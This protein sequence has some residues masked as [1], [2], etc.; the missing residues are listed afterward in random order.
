MYLVYIIQNQTLP[1]MKETSHTTT[2]NLFTQVNMLANDRLG[3]YLFIPSSKEII[4]ADLS[5]QI[6]FHRLSL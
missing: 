1:Q 3:V 2:S 6:V 4:Y 5:I